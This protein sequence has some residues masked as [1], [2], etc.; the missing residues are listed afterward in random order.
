MGAGADVDVGMLKAKD[1]E[2]FFTTN[3]GEDGTISREYLTTQAAKTFVGNASLEG[4]VVSGAIYVN[5]QAAETVDICKRPGGGNRRRTGNGGRVQGSLRDPRRAPA[6]PLLGGRRGS[7]CQLLLL[8]IRRQPGMV[9]EGSVLPHRT[10]RVLRAHLPS[11]KPS[12]HHSAVQEPA[13]GK[14]RHRGALRTASG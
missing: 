1:D 5:G 12:A 6:E 13:R 3:E 7:G 10:Y 14:T 9:G 2:F 8:H 4:D 11:C